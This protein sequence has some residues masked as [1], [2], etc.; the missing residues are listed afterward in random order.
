M[1]IT[2]GTNGGQ[3]I[4]SCWKYTP[5]NDSWEKL[6]DAPHHIEQGGTAVLQDRYILSLGST[7]G[8]DSYRVGTDL[9]TVGAGDFSMKAGVLTYCELRN[10]GCGWH[11]AGSL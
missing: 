10:S 4:R 5:A 2:L 11:A 8:R 9:S 1:P 3:L 6:P 7:H